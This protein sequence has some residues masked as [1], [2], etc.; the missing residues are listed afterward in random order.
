MVVDDD[1]LVTTVDDT[2]LESAYEV[3]TVGDEST[4]NDVVSY[5]VSDDT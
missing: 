1:P 4:Y 3:V 2:A 5:V